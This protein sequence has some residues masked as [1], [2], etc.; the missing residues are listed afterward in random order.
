MILESAQMLSTVKGGPLK[1][2]HRNHPCTRWVAESEA[3]Y[4]WL[5]DHFVA[6]LD[7]YY[8]R[9]GKRHKYAG[10]NLPAPTTGYNERIQ[11]VNCSRYPDLPVHEA[12]RR[13][14]EDKWAADKRRPTWYR[15][16]R[17]D[18]DY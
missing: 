7:E 17:T 12:Y 18:H 3:H 2:T 5:Y 15:G 11:H 16:H 10:I 6:L 9:Y 4:A 8:Q 13:T 1:P 14:L